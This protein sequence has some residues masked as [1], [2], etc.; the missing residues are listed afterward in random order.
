M[1]PVAIQGKSI[2][3]VFPDI[4]PRSWA[5]YDAA[6]KCPAGHMLGG[7]KMWNVADLR[8]WASLG[9]PDRATFERKRGD[10]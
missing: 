8:A 2:R 4:S 1:E 6:E 10:L 9:F 3:I 5:R 7:K